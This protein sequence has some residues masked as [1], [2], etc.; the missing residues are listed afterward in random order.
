[1]IKTVHVTTSNVKKELARVADGNSM[2]SSELYVEINYVNTFVRKG[3]SDFVKISDTDYNK[4]KEEVYQRDKDI[5][6]I[7]EYD[8]EILAKHEGYSFENMINEIEFIENNTSAYFVIKKG[9]KL[10]YYDELYNDFINYIM[11]QQ[12]RSNIM[13]YLFDVNYED[14]IK[15][16]VDV[17]QKI[18]AITFKE[19]KK[20]LVS[21]SLDAIKS[22]NAE[23]CMTIEENNDTDA[24]D[25]EGK[26]DYAN[27]GF[28]LSCSE[29]DELFEFIKPLQG[30]H[31]RDCRGD[32][33]EVETV[34]LD[35]KP[36]FTIDDNI[37]VQDSFENIKYLSTR[38]GYLVKKE[39][40]YEVSN[41]IDVG[42]I[43]FQTTG[44]IDTDLD[45]EISINVI[46]DDPLEDAIEKGMH[47]KV[48]NLSI[49]G[50]IGPNTQVE[51][52]SIS[53]T[54]QSHNDSFI[55]C[56]DAKIGIHKGKILGRKV[57]VQTLEGGEIVADVAIIRNAMRGKIRAKRI[58]IDTLGSHVIMEASEHIQI[59][60][61]RGEE[62][63]F[64]VE[65][66]VD[67]GFDDDKKD[68]E[69]YLKKLENELK[70]LIKVFNNSTIKMKKNLEP[71]KK[72]KAAI[73]KSKNEGIEISETLIKNFKLCKVMQV[74]YKKLKE[75]IEYK[76]S[77]YNKQKKKLSNN[78]SSVFD[79]I[80]VANKPL[81]G[82]NHIVYKID[83]L[84][85]PQLEIE[86]NTDE[87]MKEKVFKLI[88]DEDGVLKVI[89]TK[90]K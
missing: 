52:R 84:D 80:I 22:I 10:N 71:C 6:F 68:N 74:Q 14:T 47:V 67:S 43:S 1:M 17:I 64:I 42:E 2:L 37:E 51:A 72:V 4:Y 57:E 83:K 28:M 90:L 50:S 33:I 45:T 81:R 82:Y 44:T 13:L 54:G 75:N 9:S 5:K 29:G 31:G 63:R 7:Q 8:I 49:T 89:N 39:N 69:E 3:D 60:K 23:I 24:Q 58:E 36:M 41:S 77:Q 16:F 65:S 79:A 38:S 56:I 18:K 27:R 25:S 76:K 66:F 55:K 15:Q 78:I 11:E 86:L 73:M 20:I 70:S 32:I 46:K 62:N 48:Q 85:K 87:S 26:V 19:D 53:I 21:K 34:N 59:E 30:E 88:E 35:A 12:L 40:Q 61:V